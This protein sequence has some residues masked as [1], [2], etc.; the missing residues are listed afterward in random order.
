ML[1]IGQSFLYIVC[2]F[3]YVVI[4]CERGD[5]VAYPT[6]V[7]VVRLDGLVRH[8]GIVLV[9]A[10]YALALV[11]AAF[12]EDSRKAYLHIRLSFATEVIVFENPICAS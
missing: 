6:V 11:G 9:E 4:G 8:S 10:A 12:V 1:F 5:C 3:N 2:H 7:N